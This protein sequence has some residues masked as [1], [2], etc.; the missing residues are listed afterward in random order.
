MTRID[1]TSLHSAAAA[2]RQTGIGNL[3]VTLWDKALQWQE[4]AR[5][6]YAL[7]RMDEAALKDIGLSRSLAESEI[8]KP[9]WRG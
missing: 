8:N 9:F 5:S 1:S 2:H 4:R 7:S 3:L 6:R